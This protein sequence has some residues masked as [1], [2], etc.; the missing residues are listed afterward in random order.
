VEFVEIVPVP[1]KRGVPIGFQVSAG[2]G[3][4]LLLVLLVAVLAMAALMRLTGSAER[5]DDHYV[6]Y[7][8]SLSTAQL[9][10]KGMANDERGFLL[11]GDD[12]FVSEAHARAAEVRAAF[13][14]A[15]QAAVTTDQR[16]A[17]I[18][19][20]TQFERWADGVTTEIAMYHSGKRAA[21]STWSMGAG[22]EMRKRY[23]DALAAATTRTDHAIV[24]HTAAL[25][26]FASESIGVL[27][28]ALVLLLAI[29]VAVTIW[30]IRTV[31]R[32]VHSL[33]ELLSGFDERSE[34]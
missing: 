16:Q 27:T 32:P 7:A 25:S 20:E 30:L 34:V 10:A 24:S 26:T 3:G 33:V 5:L 1:R 2:I 17:V 12:V 4:L 28:G 21:A 31:L 23:E 8:T 9:G 29:G 6:P 15:A 19:A 11:T 13:A 22:R 18:S 14:S